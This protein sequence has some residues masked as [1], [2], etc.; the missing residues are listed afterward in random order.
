M[1]ETTNL[2]DTVARGHRQDLSIDP[3]PPDTSIKDFELED[4]AGLQPELENP[5]SDDSE[6]S[7]DCERW[8]EYE[9]VHSRE[10][11]KLIPAHIMEFYD[12]GTMATLADDHGGIASLESRSIHRLLRSRDEGPSAM[13]REHRPVGEKV[14]FRWIHVPANNME[15]IEVCL[16]TQFLLNPELVLILL[17]FD[18]R[19]LHREA[20]KRS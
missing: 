15:W 6:T 17:G 10:I 14:K 20:E 4:G 7:D 18:G 8:E 1:S 13:M 3:A 5:H 16:E 2:P 11:E 12:N 19:N 9:F